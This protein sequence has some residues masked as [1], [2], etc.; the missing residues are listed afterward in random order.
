MAKRNENLDEARIDQAVEAMLS[1]KSLYAA[2]QKAEIPYTSMRRLLKNEDFQKSLREARTQVMDVAL[3]RLRGLT[4]DA[5]QV[6]ADTMEGSN[7]DHLK[8]SAA[9]WVVEHGIAGLQIDVD[10]RIRKLEEA[11]NQ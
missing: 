7:Q 10:E 6:V 9:K 4:E 3:T 1:E 8:F 5:V 2:S 11:A